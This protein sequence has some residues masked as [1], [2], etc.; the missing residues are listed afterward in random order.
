[1]ATTTETHSTVKR[2][3]NEEERQQQAH[4]IRALPETDRSSLY[5]PFAMALLQ[6]P[7]RP[8]GG[9]PD[10]MAFVREVETELI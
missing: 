1:V 4:R 8:R 7:D 3:K 10:F 2:L 6:S 9:E 5:L